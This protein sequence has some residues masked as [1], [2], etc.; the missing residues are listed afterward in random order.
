MK[1]RFHTRLYEAQRD[2]ADHLGT[3]TDGW[4]GGC[5]PCVGERVRLPVGED[6]A[7]GSYDL[8]VVE[9]TYDVREAC[10][11]V[12]LHLPVEWR[13]NTLREWGDWLAKRKRGEA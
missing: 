9:V 8:E 3:I 12:E 11:L 1:I 4:F 5:A 13:G 10:V 6:R 7:L 2:V